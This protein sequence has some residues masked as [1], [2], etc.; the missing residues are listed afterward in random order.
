MN[1]NQSLYCNDPSNFAENASVNIMIRAY[2]YHENNTMHIWQ[3][4]LKFFEQ[5]E[6]HKA[7]VIC[8]QFC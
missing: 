1:D 2:K 7:Y 8:V 4:E 5:K 3:T 6:S